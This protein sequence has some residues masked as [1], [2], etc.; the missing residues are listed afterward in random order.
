MRK[1]DY[2]LY[3]DFF[4]IAQRVCAPKPYTVLL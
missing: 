4:F 3:V 2:V 1:P